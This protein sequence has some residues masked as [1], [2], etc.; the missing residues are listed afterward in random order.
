MISAE[1]KLSIRRI[2]L[3]CLHVG[4]FDPRYTSMILKYVEQ[5]REYPGQDAGYI[6]VR[7]SKIYPGTFF[8]EDG[9]HRFVAYII[10]GRKDMLC[11]VIEE[12]GQR[13]QEDY[14]RELE[15]TLNSC[16]DFMSHAVVVG[17][18]NKE[19]Y[20]LALCRKGLKLLRGEEEC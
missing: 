6:R 1:A 7:P 3:E 20:A 2:P 11:I 14:V 9:H 17:S 15:H 4:D 8:I 10:A 16:I 12:P 19:A 18:E 5:L 13:N